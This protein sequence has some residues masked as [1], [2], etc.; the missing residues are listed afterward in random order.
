[1]SELQP[2]SINFKPNI[3]SGDI[4]ATAITN[5]DRLGS[6]PPVFD[7]SDL[8]PD[9]ARDLRLQAARIRR[10]HA[11]TTKSIVET[12]RDLMATK[13][14]LDHGQFTAWVE[15]EIGL[16][17][18]TVQ[19]YMAVARLADQIPNA[20]SVSHLLPSV[21]YKLAA[22]STPAEVVNA[23]IARAES[24]EIVSD[25]VVTCMLREARWLRRQD[26]KKHLTA[27]TRSKKYRNRLA[28]DWLRT[29]KDRQQREEAARVAAKEIVRRIGIE[30][31][32]FIADA[33]REH[34]S[35]GEA[36]RLEIGRSA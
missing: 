30:S 21:V 7:Y 9:L 8:A 31:A 28:A 16:T 34:W 12:G 13:Q 5:L 32:R 19:H 22:K 33:F 18:R 25:D 27:E 36:L 2:T 29:E 15:A 20:K 24:G 1:M 35:L 6:A 11:D 17:I 4:K 3:T 23:V 10:R 14:H 26:K